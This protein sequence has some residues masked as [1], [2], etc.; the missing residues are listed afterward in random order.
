MYHRSF[1]FVG[2]REPVLYNGSTGYMIL[3]L[4]QASMVDT[5]GLEAGNDWKIRLE[6]C[7]YR[8]G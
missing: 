7:L 8:P 6:N 1:G 5:Y 2:L 4:N 3:G